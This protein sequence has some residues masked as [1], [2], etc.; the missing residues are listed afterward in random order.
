MA[1]TQISGSQIARRWAI[2]TSAFVLALTG[3]GTAFQVLNSSGTGLFQISSNGTASGARLH[4]VTELSSSGTLVFEGAASGSSLFLGTSLEGAGLLSCSNGTTSKLL[5]DSTTKRFSCGTDQNS[6]GAGG[7][8]L[9]DAD[10]R[11]VNTAGDTMTGDLFIQKGAD[12]TTYMRFYPNSLQYT[13]YDPAGAYVELSAYPGQGGYFELY[14]VPTNGSS[15]FVLETDPNFAKQKIAIPSTQN[16]NIPVMVVESGSTT[17]LWLS[18]KGRLAIGKN[19]PETSLDIV[20]TIS[21]STVSSNLLT[22]S[23]RLVI[24]SL[25]Q[26]GSGASA[27]T[28]AEFQTGSYVYGSGA[29]ILA[30]DSYTRTKAPHILFGY[31][32]TFD[33][34]LFR[35][36]PG[37]LATTGTLSGA[38]LYVATS[39]Q[40]AGL[41]DCDIAMTS[42]L[43]WDATTGRFSC[44][45]DQMVGIGLSQT[46]GDERYVNQ[47]GD[48]MTGALIINLATGTNQTVGL[49][50]LNAISGSYIVASKGLTTSG[51][52]LVETGATIGTYLT[53]NATGTGSIN[54]TSTGSQIGVFNIFNGIGQMIFSVLPSGRA[55]VGAQRTSTGSYEV[56]LNEI[57]G[58]RVGYDVLTTGVISGPVPYGLGSLTLSGANNAKPAFGDRQY[59]QYQSINRNRAVAG[60][61]SAGVDTYV[62]YQPR[63]MIDMKTGTGLT[64][65]SFLTGMATTPQATI[66]KDLSI[67]ASAGGGT[68]VGV[69]WADGV[70]GLKWMCCSG[71]GTNSSCTDMGLPVETLQNYLIDIDFTDKRAVSCTIKT[72]NVTVNRI[73]TSNLPANSY[74]SLSRFA[75]LRALALNAPS[76]AWYLSK[77]GIEQ[78]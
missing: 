53:V 33:T 51:S 55:Y 3:A 25:S 52:L 17:L 78:N 15:Q 63:F 38:S 32:G 61:Y 30:L 4:A 31:R 10:A 43:L 9:A 72:K 59:T 67:A 14:G 36:S 66:A 62:A 5:W 57:M 75:L 70:N 74:S 49:N 2:G 68:Y 41:T 42:K 69:G 44:G 65:E 8:A 35:Q 60:P 45:T 50:V 1:T 46:S 24:S 40:G 56:G 54:K 23:G 12:A 76:R 48:T 27:I 73:K 13:A 58:R 34:D 26:V 77:M 47:S 64:S 16:I 20:G 11:Y 19:T 37:V 7:L 22:S 28:P 29:P 6:G 71:D 39:L 18:P 21:G